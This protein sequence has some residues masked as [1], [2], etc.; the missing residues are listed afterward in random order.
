M[1]GTDSN[2][3]TGGAGS[4]TR[5]GAFF[6]TS[7]SPAGSNKPLASL[8]FCFFRFFGG[9]ISTSSGIISSGSLSSSSGLRF[10]TK[11]EE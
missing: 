5:L 11:M 3:T 2:G 6:G 9:D 1:I 4:L 7:A 10:A 8:F